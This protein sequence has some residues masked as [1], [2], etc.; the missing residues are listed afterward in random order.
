M[1]TS[2]I[3]TSRR[4]S[5]TRVPAIHFVVKSIFVALTTAVDELFAV[6]VARVEVPALK[7]RATWTNVGRLRADI[8][9]AEHCASVNHALNVK[10]S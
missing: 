1:D 6:A 4:L 9:A 7:V 2:S 8:Y 5:F 10:S 3:L